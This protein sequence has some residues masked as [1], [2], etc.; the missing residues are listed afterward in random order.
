MPDD[1]N[2][3][4]DPITS[5]IAELNDPEAE[6]EEFRNDFFQG[7]SGRRKKA[8]FT[9]TL[10]WGVTIGLHLFS[11]S[12][13]LVAMLGI[14]I[15]IQAL[16]LMLANP[17]SDNF[18]PFS[19]IEELPFVSLL[20]SA[21]NEEQVIGKLVKMLLNIKYPHDRYELWIVDDNSN[22]RTGKIL[23]QLA[24]EHPQLNVLHRD[25]LAKGG[26][27]GALNQAYALSKGDIIAVFDADAIIPENLLQEVVPLFE[28]EKMGAV[29]VRKAVSNASENFWTLGQKVEMALD[30]YFQRQ[31]INTGGIGE[32]RGNGQFVRRSAL[33]SCGGWNE[34]TITDD[35]DLTIRL[36]LD[37][38]DIEILEHPAVEE[39]GVKSAIALWHQRSRWAEGGYQR[40]FDYW[41]FIL[42]NRLSWSKKFDLIF[43]FMVQYIF[44]TAAIPDL[45]MVVTRHRLP[46]V[47]PLS[48][49]TLILAFWGMFTGLKRSQPD[50]PFNLKNITIG[51][52]QS[53]L[54]MIYMVHWFIVMPITTGRISFRQ[55]RLKWVK[56]VHE[57]S[58][59]DNL[60]LG[61]TKS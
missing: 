32:L 8:A 48:S 19:E 53:F 57:G 40:Y 34:E 20:V 45:L 52:A 12:I 27:S 31:R 14:F 22:D 55:K 37:G 5:L 35:L 46:L 54:G 51:I 59:E 11:W 17:E 21:K 25:S 43:F 44:P 28:V 58:A 1:K 13:F 41:R 60:E 36:H 42:S 6:E 10:V 16:R 50:K 56:T 3:E 24:L 47:A 7:L 38:W 33:D 39:E 30:S 23:D 9:L 4:I 29:Q 2:Q 18:T 49:L 15:T 61:L 26:K